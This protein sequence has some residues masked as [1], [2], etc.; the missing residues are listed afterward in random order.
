MIRNP[1]TGRDV[2]IDAPIGKAIISTLEYL[3]THDDLEYQPGQ[4]K[5]P[6]TNRWVGRTQPLGLV[7]L[8]TAEDKKTGGGGGGGQ[9]KEDEEP[10]E[11][12][13][14]RVSLMD[15]GYRFRAS[16]RQRRSRRKRIRE[17]D[18]ELAATYED[19]GGKCQAQLDEY[20]I[21]KEIGPDVFTVCLS[22]SSDCRYVMKVIPIRYFDEQLRNLMITSKLGVTPRILRWW[23][24][25]E[26]GVIIMQRM[27]ETVAKF[28]KRNSKHTSCYRFIVSQLFKIIRVLRANGLDIG[29][30]S[31]SD[32]MLLGK[33]VFL[34][35]WKTAEEDSQ[36]KDY[37]KILDE[38]MARCPKKFR[39]RVI[40]QIK[41]M[42]TNNG[43][44]NRP[45]T[46]V[47]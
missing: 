47:L 39:T 36:K 34:I 13:D 22:G 45:L 24:C 30:L 40:Q 16:D 41:D 11:P 10:P 37:L 32:L 4:V 29:K 12:V 9:R 19:I 8:K 7:I 21:L 2:K 20:E 23:S 31:L 5:N 27:D 33:R 6:A 25:G 3:E 46:A 38:I 17:E 26:S 28:M 35:G 18:E 44:P 43:V 1:R 42:L 15:V 14:P